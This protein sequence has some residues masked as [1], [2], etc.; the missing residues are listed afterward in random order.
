[1][2]TKLTVKNVAFLAALEIVVALVPFTTS[3]ASDTLNCQYQGRR[4]DS[5]ERSQPGFG[6]IFGDV[7]LVNSPSECPNNIQGIQFSGS[8]AADAA[9]FVSTIE[10]CLDMA[11]LLVVENGLITVD[12]HDPLSGEEGIVI[13]NH[14]ALPVVNSCRISSRTWHRNH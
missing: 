14:Q 2:Q 8:S 6:I 13:G 12:L 3:I 9:T 7:K 5:V 4:L 10:T 11:S 1:M